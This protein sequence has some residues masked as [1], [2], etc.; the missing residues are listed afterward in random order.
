MQKIK[1]NAK[2]KPL[3]TAKQQIIVIV[4]G[5]GSGK[6]IGVADILTIKMLTEAAD[7][8]CLREFQDSISD[9]VHRTIAD[10][11]NKRLKLE[12]WDIQE[13][14]IIAPNGARTVYKG[15]NRN[16][17]SMQSAQ[18]YKYSWFE[19]AHRASQ[20]SIDKLL[21]TILRNKGAK[22]I[23][24]ANPQSSADPFSQRFINPYLK[25][26]NEKGIYEDDLH[27]IIK[28]NWRD[29]PW[30][31]EEQENLRKWDYE[32]LSRAKYRW[33][34]EGDFYDEVDDSIIPV[35]WFDAAIDAHKIPRLEKLFEPHG[36]VITAHDPSGT[37]DDSKGLAIRHGSIIR[38]V[39]EKKAGDIDDGIDWATKEALKH[40]SDWFVWDGDGM[41]AGCKRQIALNLDGTKCQYHMFR[42][43]LSGKGQDNAEQLYMGDHGAKSASKT[44]AETFKNNRAQYYIELAN[45]FHNTYK[46]VVKGEYIDPEQMISLDSEGIE[47]IDTLRSEICRVQRKKNANGLE[48]IKSKDEMKAEGI[49]SP[50]MADSV[51]MSLFKPPVKKVKKPIKYQRARVV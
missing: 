25:E 14:K 3:F 24:T 21:P 10:S 34:W 41:G 29:N 40:N 50:N 42:G 46:C 32:H 22:C 45:R 36:A 19:E 7:I 35:E 18:G 9:S 17:D 48:Q 43:S 13:N 20:S 37:G 5:R 23:F 11:I 12:S 2:L 47:D 39:A 16:P 8:Y 33:I 49:N 51:M 27:L 44:Y 15:A 4:G 1:I 6:S 28:L 30:W 38:K 31:N 26:L